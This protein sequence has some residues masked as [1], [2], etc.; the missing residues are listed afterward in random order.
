MQGQQEQQAQ[1]QNDA[2]DQLRT[3]ARMLMVNVLSR[4]ATRRAPTFDYRPRAL[5]ADQVLAAHGTPS[6]RD[7]AT[8]LAVM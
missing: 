7:R 5:R 3:G 1:H 4:C 8:A 6:G 2:D